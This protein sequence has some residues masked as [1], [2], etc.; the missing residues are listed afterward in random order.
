M[1]TSDSSAIPVAIPTVNRSDG[2]DHR[3]TGWLMKHRVLPVG[4]ESTGAHAEPQAWWKVMC[5][6]GV[7]YF[8]TL[9]YLPGIAALAAGALSPLA[10]L[11]I[12]A[13]TLLGMLPMYRR[14]AEE[15]PGGQGSVAMLE[16]LLS[17]WKGKLFVLVLLGFVVTSW[18]ITI[19]LSGADA[20]VHLLQNPYAPDVLAGHQVLITVVLL[21]VL[22]GVFL[23][24]FTE[25]V[26]V[27]IPV[28]GAF[29]LLNAV[30]V[31][32]GLARVAREPALVTGWT[33]RLTAGGT[34][35]ADLLLPAVLAFPLLVLGLSGFET[36]VS[37]MPLVRVD[38]TTPAE[39]LASRIRNTRRLLT[40]AAIIMSGY[41]VTTSIVTT[42]LIPPAEFE[43]GGEANGRALAY[44]AHENL[45][46][47]FGTA[48]DLSSMLILWFAGASAMAGLINIVPRYLPSYGMA[49]EWGT[50]IRP[51]VLV[52]TGLSIA[53]TI[54]F[55]ADVDAQAGAY[56]TGILAMM[57]SASVAVTIACARA[58]RRRATA[59]FGF[60]TL[61]LSYALVDNVITAPDG[62]AISTGFIAGIIV[63]SLVSRVLRTTELRADRVELDEAARQWV[64]DSLHHD[65]ALNL[66]GNRRETGHP[67]EYADKERSQRSMNPLPPSADIIF[68]EIEVVDPSSF[69]DVLR[70]RGVEVDGHR[71]LRAASPA[72]PNAIAAIL[73]ALRDAT[74]VRPHA[75]F[76]WTEGNPI[77]HLLRYLLLGRGD[78]AP[79]VREII[80]EN[81]PD[82]ERRPVVHVGG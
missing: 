76:Q 72:A 57:V 59:A 79:V 61:V 28:V 51:V 74:G 4:P 50:A 44:L 20:T 36:G 25:A 13:L 21:L 32:D 58:H 80:R 15:S 7:D 34:G 56:A 5:L 35:P 66:V 54:A 1:I 3:P 14:V 78:T 60:L 75:H 37:M 17:F 67:E 12:V 46:N 53:L 48:Y 16:R 22:G 18:I 9:S 45:G 30:V 73:L 8:S 41:L 42:L 27:A 68:L 11:L 39:R 52:F 63:V 38:G 70:V 77:G 33:E 31:V 71:I 43:P 24:G 29:L 40:T 6:T 19:T 81:E 47:S 55:S 64:A 62:L 65:G 49:P 23:L 26:V 69:S 2:P 10:T 82:P